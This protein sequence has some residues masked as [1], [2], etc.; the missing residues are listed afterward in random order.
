MY[1]HYQITESNFDYI[2]TFTSKFYATFSCFYGVIVL[3]LQLKKTPFSISFKTGQVVT[4]FLSFYLFRQ[5]FPSSF[6]RDSFTRYRNLGFFFQYFRYVNLLSCVKS[7][8]EQSDN[9]L[10]GISLYITSV[11]SLATFKVPSLSFKLT[12]SLY[13]VL[14]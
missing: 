6:L 14:V 4:K 13:C 11:F 8:N 2:C 9:Y 7:F 5:V 12:I 10:M 1:H 3:L